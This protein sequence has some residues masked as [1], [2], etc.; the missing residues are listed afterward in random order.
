MK[1]SRF[2]ATE[3]HRI[4]KER[5]VGVPVADLCHKHGASDASIYKWK[6]WFGF[7]GVSGANR[8]S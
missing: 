7:M 5:E 6:A 8:P 2:F 3:D 4:L 1:R